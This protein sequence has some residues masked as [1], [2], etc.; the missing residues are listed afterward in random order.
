VITATQM[1][2]SMI[3]SPQPTRAEVSDVANAVLDGTDAVML[4]A[5]TAVGD[6]P[7]ATVQAMDRIILGAER[8]YQSRPSEDRPEQ[9]MSHNDEAIARAAMHVANHL[10]GVKAIIAMTETGTTPRLMSRV[11]SGMP[12]FA[13]TP[14]PRTRR[15]V[16]IYRGVE[17]QHF[18]MAGDPGQ[19]NRDAA[20]QLQRL[21]LVENGDR[22]I[23]T[24]GDAVRVGGGTNTLKIITV[25]EAGD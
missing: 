11:R 21:G 19:V 24:K 15:R 13:F 5:E 16:A 20:A 10:S 14:D 3:H 8:T 1:M 17:P 2:E 22:L 4:S 6:Y 9:G 23:L 12:I 18:E 25:G 7:V